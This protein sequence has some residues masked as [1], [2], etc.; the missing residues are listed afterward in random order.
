ML[1]PVS[2][3]SLQ[4]LPLQV[5]PKLKALN[6]IHPKDLSPKPYKAYLPS[7]PPTYRPN[8]IRPKP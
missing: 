6:P 1:D 5:L 8:L 3:I 7:T 4:F 2:H